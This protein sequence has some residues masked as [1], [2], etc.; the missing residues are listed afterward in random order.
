MLLDPEGEVVTALGCYVEVGVRLALDD[1]GTGS[2]SLLHLR[3]VPVATV[4]IDRAFVDGLGRSRQDG[5]IVRALLSLTSDLGPGCVAEGVE[6]P[7]QRDWL[8]AQ[9]VLVAQGNLLHRRLPPDALEVLLR[10]GL[11]TVAR[12]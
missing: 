5:A 6:E 1:V 7:K 8:V 3:H 4:K 9:G 2:S 11:G 10:D 12:G